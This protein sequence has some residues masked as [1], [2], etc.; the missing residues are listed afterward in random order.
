MEST[1]NETKAQHYKASFDVFKGTKN[2]VESDPDSD[3][4][5]DESL[6]N[7]DKKLNFI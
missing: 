4:F 2:N 5:N 3:D 6:G 1:K 7:Q